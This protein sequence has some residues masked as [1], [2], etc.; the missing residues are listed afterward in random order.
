M[1]ATYDKRLP[2]NQDYSIYQTRE[3]HYTKSL[4]FVNRPRK[5]VFTAS[6]ELIL[7]IF[8]T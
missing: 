1:R 3:N 7:K 5:A 4:I 6:R 8:L 2:L